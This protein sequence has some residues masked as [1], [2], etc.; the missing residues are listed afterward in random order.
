MPKARPKKSDIVRERAE[1]PGLYSEIL[2]INEQ[3]KRVESQS[4]VLI[5]QMNKIEKALAV[6]DK[7]LAVLSELW[8]RPDQMTPSEHIIKDF[9][10]EKYK[11]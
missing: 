3:L 10:R 7:L 4:K 11:T 6:Y 2:A 1:R 9:L 8:Q 5:I